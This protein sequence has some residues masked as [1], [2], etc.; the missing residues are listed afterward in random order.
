MERFLH[1]GP[2][3][4]WGF[5]NPN[6]TAALIA[7]LMIAVWA[8]AF[9]RRVGFWVALL[10]CLGLGV[11][12]IQTLSRGGLAAF[13]CGVMILLVFAPRPWPL[14][15]LVAVLFACIA[16]GWFVKA[17]NGTAR[18][19]RAL[20]GEDKSISGRTVI[21][22][23]APRMMV[24][25]PNGWGFENAA[26]AY[27]QWYQPTEDLELY[28]NLLSSH[29]TWLV[30]V[31]WFLRFGYFFGWSA[32]F[33]LCWPAGENRWFVVSLGIWVA[34]AV[35]ASFSAVAE[36]PWLWILPAA[37]LIAVM[38]ARSI[39]RCWPNLRQWFIPFTASV[40]LI[41]GLFAYGWLHPAPVKI[42]GECSKVFVGS[43]EPL[44]WVVSPDKKIMGDH[45]GHA[46]RQAGFAIS[47]AKTFADVPKKYSGTIVLMGNPYQPFPQREFSNLVILNPS[48]DP[49]K[50]LN[51]VP[52]QSVTVVWGEFR[53]E[54]SRTDWEQWVHARTDSH[55]TEAKGYA[56]YIPDWLNF[57]K[58]QFTTGK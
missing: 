40:V 20:S 33:L 16:L 7:T 25:A 17:T 41:A 6:K 1:G 14:A 23:V 19:A 47:V 22:S 34:L 56:E 26:Q 5:G 11:C 32:I 18:Y 55:F 38:M 31:N 10:L 37:S 44:L 49:D 21:Y 24:D 28:K 8:V 42:S 27:M 15:R 54:D 48:G 51:E 4:D 35:A 9:V 29:L 58:K 2:R 45:Y 36:S 39:Q 52:K 43:G 53:R 13:L 30:E 50:W 12:L 3:L 46:I 57:V